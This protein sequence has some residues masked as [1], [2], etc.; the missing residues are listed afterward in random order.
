MHDLR[1]IVLRTVKCLRAW[2]DLFHFTLRSNISQFYKEN[3]LMLCSDKN[4]AESKFY[5]LDIFLLI[6][7]IYYI[8]M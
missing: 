8:V 2:V 3:Y 6:V 7:Y 4:C 5:P 1:E